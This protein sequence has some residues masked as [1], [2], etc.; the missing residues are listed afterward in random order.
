[1][2]GHIGPEAPELNKE[3]LFHKVQQTILAREARIR[4][5][6]RLAR[7]AAAL[8]P[9]F[10]AAGVLFYVQKKG[11]PVTGTPAPLI[12]KNASPGSLRT[13]QLSDGT[14]VWLNAG[15]SLRFPETFQGG[16]REV[17]LRG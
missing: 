6:K 4:L 15:S 17:Y 8:V 12:E 1:K 13:L 2:P 9:L 5:R 16:K 11:Q 3:F 14:K 7:I 10:F